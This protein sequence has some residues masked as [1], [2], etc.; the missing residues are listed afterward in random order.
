MNS[1]IAEEIKLR[2]EPVAVIFTDEKPDSAIQFK[3]GSWGCAIAMFTASARGKIAVFDRKTT[4]CTGA[5]SGLCFGQAY[6]QI[7]GGFEYFLSTGRGEGYPEGEAY[8]KSPELVR[9]FVEK[10]PTTDLPTEYVV[11][12]PLSEVDPEKEKPALVSFY[13]NPDQLGALVV[14]ANYRRPGFDNVMIPFGS[15]CS[16]VCMF[17]YNESQ[18]ERPRAV[19]GVLDVSAR[20]YIDPDL[21][22]F[23]VPYEMFVEME[24]DVPGSFLEK[25]SWKKV[26]S[27]IPGRLQ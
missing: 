19:V 7:P 20:P 9:D 21:L 6:D 17:P 16:T 15:A 3:E 13:V 25:E 5:V 11:F 10:L 1:R 14:L 24:E 23:T 26:R 27:R 4:G 12:K 18:T 22:A 2:Y 8:K